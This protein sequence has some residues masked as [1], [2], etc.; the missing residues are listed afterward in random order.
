MEALV[1]MFCE[2]PE[3]VESDTM[4]FVDAA[5]VH[6]RLLIQPELQ[7]S[8][9]VLKYRSKTVVH[10]RESRSLVVVVGSALGI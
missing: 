7:G 4:E 6:A 3:I 2:E 10:C 9:V 5:E 8:K 1:P